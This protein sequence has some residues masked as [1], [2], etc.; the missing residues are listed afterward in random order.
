MHDAV[1]H[2]RSFPF[3]PMRL[4]PKARVPQH[5][6]VVLAAASNAG[7]L[8][9]CRSIAW[10]QLGIAI[11]KRRAT[12]T[13]IDGAVSARRGASS[14]SQGH[15]YT[16]FRRALERGNL[17][18]AEATAKELPRLGLAD[19]LELTLLVARKDPRRHPRVAARWLLRYLEEDGEATIDE[20][21]FADSRLAALT[22][23]G[24]PEAAQARG[25]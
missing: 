17:M 18:A 15:P 19:A 7:A 12:G 2:L 10:L 23:N 21:A 22:G 13:R 4:S 20:L 6:A 25:T 5:L 14:T 1:C 16:I 3:D 11:R 24:Y 9:V 8:I